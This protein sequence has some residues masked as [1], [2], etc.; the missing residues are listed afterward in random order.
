[1]KNTKFVKNGIWS[2][3]YYTILLAPGWEIHAGLQSWDDARIYT[4][5]YESWRDVADAYGVDVD[6]IKAVIEYFSPWEA[7]TI[8][9]KE[10]E[11]KKFEL[12]L[13]ES[14]D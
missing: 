5:S 13:P 4:G 14:H 1:M 10:K 8:S 2:N 6:S 9:E 11:L 3:T 12:D 7:E